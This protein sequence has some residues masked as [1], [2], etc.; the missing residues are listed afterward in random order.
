MPDQIYLLG[1]LVIMVAYMA[2]MVAIVVPVSR[3]GQLRTNKLA[4][5]TALIFMSCSVGHGLH[6]VT[7]YRTLTGIDMHQPGPWTW[8]LPLWD[9]LTATIGVYYWTLRRGYGVLLERGAIYVDP[10]GLRRIE[11]AEQDGASSRAF[12]ATVAEHID[13]AI[14]GADPDGIITAWNRGAE[15]LFGW[16]AAEII[17]RPG[18]VL[19]DADGRVHQE[20]VLAR[21]RGGETDIHYV[22]RRMRKDGASV[23]VSFDVA[24]IHGSAGEVVGIAAVARNV[25]AAMEAAEQQRAMAE[26]SHQAQRMESLGKLAGGVAHDFNNLLAIITN[27][28]EFA[29]E[30]CQDKPEVRA[31]LSHVRTASERATNLT[32]QLLTFTRGD[33]IQPQLM[34]LN[35]AIAEVHAMLARTIGED[36]SLITVPSA[37]PVC[38]VADPGQIQQV[39]LNL[40]I[41]A[42]DAMPEGGTLVLE[43]NTAALG[44]D[45]V[46]MQPPLPAG[47]YARMLV[48]DTGEGMPAGVAEHIFEPFFTT[49]PHGKGTGLGL[50]T[51]YGIVTEAGGS[52]NLYSEPGIGTTF[53]I[54]LPLADST[55]GLGA[56]RAR[57][58][59]RGGE[60][61]TVLVVE[62][63]PALARVVARILHNGGYH[64]VT[65]ENGPAALAADEKH[66]CDVLLTD[67]IMPEMSGPR[68]VEVLRERRPE[69]PVL[70]MSGYSNGLLGTTHVLDGDIAFIEKPFTAHDLLHKLQDVLN[71]APVSRA[72]PGPG[73]R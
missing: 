68:L 15:R 49:K 70:Y 67:V 25:T 16:T 62:D 35:P 42:R 14:I 2:I 8:A 31:D 64:V 39:L 13:D 7:A 51:V 61:R 28:T 26:R 4:T 41:N 1:N 43:V 50:A 37:E 47:T 20:S 18:A 40:A 10:W 34:E 46:D 19:A 33:A 63:E 3:A 36:I 48:S 73:W 55:A 29:D 59:P 56:S 66:P 9:A 65:V 71:G 45:E 23:D 54:Y 5:T 57:P 22:V 21:I 53:R 44:G 30:Q 27:Y 60:G 32:R 6:A 17:G 58:A 38:V 11:E 52:I 24:P 72:G 69:L 12:L